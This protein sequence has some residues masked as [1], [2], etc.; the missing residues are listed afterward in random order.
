ML[1][2]FIHIKQTGLFILMVFLVLQHAA[3]QPIIFSPDQWPK[4]W[5][6]V[7]QYPSMTVAARS[8]HDNSMRRV[9]E[10]SRVRYQG[11]GQ[12]KNIQRHQ[13]S[14]TPEYNYQLY[15]RY[16]P[17]PLSQRYALPESFNYTGYPLTGLYGSPLPVYPP[18]YSAGYPSV[19]P[20][21]YPGAYPGWGMTGMGVPGL[22]GTGLPYA[23]PLYLAPGLYPGAGYPW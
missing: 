17:V 11:W 14:H 22:P 23:T 9:N 16:E 10:S 21:F 4:R 20:G 13:R 6:R 1:K 3:A 2:T 15:K 8:V 19:Y 12:Q 7:M 5:E 18:L